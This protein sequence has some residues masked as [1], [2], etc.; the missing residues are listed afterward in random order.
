M[1]KAQEQRYKIYNMKS[2]QD[3]LLKELGSNDQEIEQKLEDAGY[4]QPDQAGKLTQ[5]NLSK[6]DSKS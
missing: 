5:D 4:T 3:D 1:A 2:N 6:M